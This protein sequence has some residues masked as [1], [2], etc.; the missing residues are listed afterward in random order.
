M[1]IGNGT[2]QGWW[3]WY[4]S[5]K[6]HKSGYMWKNTGKAN[7]YLDFF[8]EVE[9]ALEGFLAPKGLEALDVWPASLYRWEMKLNFPSIVLKFER[10]R[11]LYLQLERP[12]KEDAVWS[13][14]L[15]VLHS[16]PSY[17][18]KREKKIISRYSWLLVPLLKRQNSW[19][20]IQEYSNY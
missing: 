16:F 11:N 17:K 15:E 1:D 8:E 19:W 18:N 7:H 12:L 9:E 2:E 4:E 14:M 3:K 6:F 5:A 13:L 10:K 20:S